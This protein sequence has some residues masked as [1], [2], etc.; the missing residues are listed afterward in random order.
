MPE[1]PLEKDYAAARERLSTIYPDEMMQ[2]S[3][4]K[5]SAYT[6]FEGRSFAKT[7]LVHSATG[8]EVGH[9]A[10]SPHSGQIISTEID[11]SHRLGGT[12][13]GRLLH[14]SWKT[15]S[16][17]NVAGPVHGTA[18]D[19]P[20][21]PSNRLGNAIVGDALRDRVNVDS[22][23]SDRFTPPE[24]ER[25][26]GHTW[27]YGDFPSPS[28]VVQNA[29]VRLNRVTIGANEAVEDA[30]ITARTIRRREP[31]P[32]P[33]SDSTYSEVVDAQRRD[34]LSRFSQEQTE[35]QFDDGRS[36][37]AAPLVV[38]S[39][40][41]K[42][43][44]EIIGR[45]PT[46]GELRIPTNEDGLCAVCNNHQMTVT[47]AR[48]PYIRSHQELGSPDS[49][50]DISNAV[51]EKLDEPLQF[52]VSSMAH[53]GLA[54]PLGHQTFTRSLRGVDRR[55]TQ[56]EG[57]IYVNPEESDDGSVHNLLVRQV[58]RCPHCR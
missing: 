39:I 3:A 44:S 22:E 46:D 43:F 1:L 38:P 32:I 25:R 9:I 15:A 11:P 54:H 47:T 55:L 18:N 49:L 36:W 42:S 19:N 7:T 51:T 40:L 10:W 58:L 5:Y 45:K 16:M 56:H 23:I 57:A 8:E 28:T 20:G 50:R 53:E 31:T 33:N 37:R 17:M 21:T 48:I 35:S 26:Q 4:D 52:T 34:A 41:P 13:F 30:A 12:N 29:A 24:L 6:R 2:K 27:G 14:D